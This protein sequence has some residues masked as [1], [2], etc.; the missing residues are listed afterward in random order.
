MRSAVARSLPLLLPASSLALILA[1]CGGADP[2]EP[3]PGPGPEIQ[4]VRATT[5]GRAYYPNGNWPAGGQGQP[6][7]GLSCIA[8]MAPNHVHAH[9]SW[10][11]PVCGVRR[12]VRLRVG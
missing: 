3:D 4:L 12:R 8:G 6:I 11:S 10:S 1:G 2:V 7:S 5:T 9:L